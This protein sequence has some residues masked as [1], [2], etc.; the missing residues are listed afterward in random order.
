MPKVIVQF[1]GQEWPIVLREG[2]NVVGRSPQ[3]AVPIKDPS[4]SREHCDILLEEGVATL[5]DRGSMNGTL[6]NGVRMDRR[7]LEAGDRIQI[8]KVTLFFEQKQEGGTAPPA[9]KAAEATPAGV[10]DFSFWQR[11]SGG[12]MS[13]VVALVVLGVIAAGAVY[14][15]RT[16]GKWRGS[17]RRGQPHR[18]RRP[19]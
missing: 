19:V 12:L 9:S 8:G 13:A 6:I 2:I 11:E 3:A 16:L 4:M 7:V 1:G 17:G 18:R 10:E 15:F 14:L 5:V